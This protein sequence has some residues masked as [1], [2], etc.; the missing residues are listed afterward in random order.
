MAIDLSLAGGVSTPPALAS[1]K[2]WLFVMGMDRGGT[3]ITTQVLNTHPELSVDQE[4]GIVARCQHFGEWIRENRDLTSEVPS[5][6]AI[7]DDLETISRIW[8]RHLLAGVYGYYGA[9]PERWV[10]DKL[11]GLLYVLPYLRRNYPGA[12]FLLNWREPLGTLA[13]RKRMPWRQGLSLPEKVRAYHDL[14]ARLQEAAADPDTYLIRYERLCRQPREVFAEVAVFLDV[15]CQF[16]L[17]A[18]QPRPPHTLSPEEL[19][20]IRAHARLLEEAW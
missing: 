6:P 12:R 7:S 8:E 13:S 4:R 3:T 20:Y 18:I 1:G 16:N 2:R 15:P 9:R 10:G 17:A 5:H 14:V 11:P 19:E